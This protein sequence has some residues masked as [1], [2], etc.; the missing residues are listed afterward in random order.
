MGAKPIKTI[1]VG[2]AAQQKQA[3]PSEKAIRQAQAAGR[4]LASGH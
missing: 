4:Q 3:M 1:F 2:L